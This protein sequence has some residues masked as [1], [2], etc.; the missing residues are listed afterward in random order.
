LKP[1]EELPIW[2]PETDSDRRLVKKELNAILASPHFSNSRRYPALLRYVVEKCLDGQTDHL[3]ERTLGIEVFNR[4]PDYDTSADP[5]VRFSAGEVRK[6][7]AQYYQG[8]VEESE[9]QIH[10]PLG[11]Y[12]PEFR[13]ELITYEPA[14]DPS[15]EPLPSET[16]ECM[17]LPAGFRVSPAVEPTGTDP[18]QVR[19]RLAFIVLIGLLL[20]LIGL[21]AY[22][23]F[24]LGAP[25]QE[26]LLWKPLLQTERPILIVLG[27]G[28]LSA[29]LPEPTETPLSTHMIGPY[30]HVSVSSAV[31]LS[32][33][34]G[35]LEKRSKTYTI[36][37]APL[38]S[39]TDLRQQ[40][41]IFIG[42]L[43]NEWTL[44]LTDKLR[45][46]FVPGPLARIKDT[47]DPN[48]ARWSVDF[49]KPYTSVTIDYG[50]VVRYHDKSTDGDVLILAGLGPYGTEAVSEFVSSPQYL[51]QIEQI[52]P[53]GLK[54]ANVE[55]VIST[56]V[57][58]AEA[59][60]PHL[61]AACTF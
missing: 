36:K 37:E 28:S 48:N 42:G 6:R 52:V 25:N 3:K 5:V 50:I 29:V 26:E 9:I 46:Q 7:L 21:G 18:A 34:T 22:P 4:V 60:S 14:D 33:I 45:Y 20:A 11:S 38:T 15:S 30:H 49:S 59:G 24:R 44:R 53:H 17:E 31:A 47:K 54:N 1:K 55:M 27:S 12:T 57:I 13:R 43:N 2:T 8:A 58:S 19:R 35:M 51:E 61:V 56:D 39:L 23:L 16:A 32:R 10:L 40:S 41:A